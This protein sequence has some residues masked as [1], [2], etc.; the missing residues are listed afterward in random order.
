MDQEFEIDNE[1]DTKIKIPKE[2]KKGIYTKLFIEIL[3][4]I[5]I[6]L[7]F[8]FIN[9]GYIKLMQ[10]VF[11]HI[12][13]CSSGVLIIA[14]VVLFEMAYDKGK[15]RLAIY[16]IEMLALSI[17]T[18]FIPYVYFRRSIRFMNI[19]SLVGAYIS[20][21]YCIKSVV[22]Y[23]REVRKYKSG[24]SDIKEITK[25]ENESYLNE[26]SQR[27]FNDV[28]ESYDRNTN[29]TLRKRDRI[30]QTL[31][32][33]THIR[34]NDR[35]E[36]ITAEEATDN[37]DDDIIEVK[38]KFVTKQE[39]QEDPKPKKKRGRPRKNPVRSMATEG[40]KKKKDGE[41]ND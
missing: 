35:K 17:I 20:A 4:A 39:V 33:I 23:F 14:T 25:E 41:N 19:Y 9:L 10:D 21:Y 12:V 37:I 5:V 6:S 34:K 36:I 7:Y 16:G 15:G 13:H 32:K 11:T 27:K 38:E 3:I 18:L 26:A 22:V 2:I 29:S 30:K 40:R 8:L 31:K 24:R 1:L 28:D